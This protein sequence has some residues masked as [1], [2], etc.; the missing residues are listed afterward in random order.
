MQKKH[1]NILLGVLAVFVVCAVVLVAAGAWFAMSVLHHEDA[2]EQAASEAFAKERQHF[3][4]AT[5]VFELRAGGAALTR[6]VPTTGSGRLTTMH[7]L[8]WDPDEESLMRADLPFALL[9]MK[10]GPI[11]IANAASEGQRRKPVPIRVSDIE[12][13]GPALLIDQELEDGQRILIWTD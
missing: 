10:E 1:V 3:A 2:D 5:P 6:P 9:R 12:R 13:F 7:V 8:N 11:D 4:G